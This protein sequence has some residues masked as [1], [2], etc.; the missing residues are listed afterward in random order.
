MPVIFSIFNVI[1]IIYNKNNLEILKKLLKLTSKSILIFYGI[2][3]KNDSLFNNYN[4][5][6]YSSIVAT[7]IDSNKIINHYSDIIEDE[8]NN[9]KNNNLDKIYVLIPK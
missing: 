6:I 3:D 5:A 4:I 7:R 1:S 8:I 2:L 9:E